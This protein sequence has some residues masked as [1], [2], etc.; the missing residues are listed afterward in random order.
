MEI[1]F[2]NLIKIC[3]HFKICNETQILFTKLFKKILPLSQS[4]KDT[5]IIMCTCLWLSI[6][7]FE[8]YYM[9]AKDIT[10]YCF[11]NGNIDENFCQKFKHE[12]IK[13]EIKI[14][15]YLNYDLLKII[16]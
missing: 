15:N 16:N 3:K 10:K 9:T 6:K 4:S 14:L 12:M 2:N 11:R 5:L 8:C 1:Y 7:F 13:Y